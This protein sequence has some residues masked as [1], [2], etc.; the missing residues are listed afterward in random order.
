MRVINVSFSMPTYVST[1][2]YNYNLR[3]EQ[4]EAFSVP[5]YSNCGISVNYI[6]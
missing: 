5:D 2:P 6:T 3:C 4:S 1:Y